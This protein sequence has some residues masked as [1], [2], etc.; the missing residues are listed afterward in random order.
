MYKRSEVL[1]MCQD[2]LVNASDFYIQKFVNYRGKTRDTGEYYTEIVAEFVLKNLDA[3]R[4]IPS[5]Q[6]KATYK[7]ANHDGAF[8]EGSNR[9]EEIVAMRLF[10]Q[11]KGGSDYAYIGKIIDYQTP[12]KSSRT[13]GGRNVGKIDL[14]SFNKDENTV[15]ILEL[16]RK[17]STETMLR[18][19]LEAY[20]YYKT[21]DGDKLKKDFG[22]CSNTQIRVCPL[23]FR[24]GEQWKEMQGKR[25]ELYKLIIALNA[26]P[27][28]VAETNEKFVIT[29]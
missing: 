8:S 11:C 6:R 4:T 24:G 16:K 20:T 25:A 23:V 2:A 19:V 1:R 27:Y 10:N 26:T 28:Y 21:V 9:E 3:F 12:L 17:D 5:I 13:H 18:C 29:R 14:L 7:T 22:L 15:F